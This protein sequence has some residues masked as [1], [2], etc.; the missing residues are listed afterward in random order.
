MDG[1]SHRHGE[2]RAS[3]EAIHTPDGLPR[4]CGARNDGGHGAG[5]SRGRYD[6]GEGVAKDDAEAAKWYRRAAEQGDARH[7]H[8]GIAKRDG[9]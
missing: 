9:E 2:E 4:P 7:Q 6:N 8:H 1:S 3:N 5:A